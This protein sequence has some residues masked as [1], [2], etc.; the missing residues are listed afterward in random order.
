MRSLDPRALDRLGLTATIASALIAIGGRELADRVADDR[1][2]RQ[3]A[4]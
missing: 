2:E 4:R 3:R 1:D